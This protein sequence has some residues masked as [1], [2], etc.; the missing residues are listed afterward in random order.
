MS[1][2]VKKK[3]RNEVYNTAKQYVE[4]NSIKTAAFPSI[5]TGIYRF[6]LDKAVSIAASEI[7]DF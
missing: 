7:S 1:E 6:P 2:E 3:I 5:S 4:E